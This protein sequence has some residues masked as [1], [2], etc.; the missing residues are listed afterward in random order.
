MAV[1]PRRLV[2]TTA[3]VFVASI[4]W[5]VNS[6]AQQKNW[7]TEMFETLSHDFRTVGRGTKSEFHF[8]VKNKYKDD[9]RIVSASSS[10]GCTTPTIT[11]QLLKSGEEGAIIAKFNTDTFIG[12]KAATIKV[13]FDKPYFTEVQL[14]ISG[15]IR[16]DITFDPPEIAYGELKSGTGATQNVT[17]SH[18]GNSNWEIVDVR[19]HCNHLQVRLDKPERRPGLVRYRM[20][21]T[22]KDSVPEGDLRE[23]LTLISND[24]AFPTTEMSISGYVRPS[25]S[26]SPANVSIGSINV[27][28]EVEKR[29]IVRGEQPFQIKEVVCADKRFSF[30][31]PTGSKKIHFVKLRF[32]ANQGAAK[33]GQEVRIVTDL[34][35]SKSAICVVSGS[36]AN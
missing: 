34:P 18:N 10:C 32:K 9:V 14:K 31:V 26:L 19:S 1:L 12:K 29:I 33:I 5:S 2:L 36:V 3:I 25:L 8:A 28:E 16:T 22:L 4:L 23:R 17:I 27:G 13:V 6:Y 35:S 24:R 7:A 21:V 20:Q 11:K 30:D 15:F